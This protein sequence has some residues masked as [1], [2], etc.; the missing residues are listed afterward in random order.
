MDINTI[1]GLLLW[2]EAA[3]DAKALWFGKYGKWR[4]CAVKVHVLSP[5]KGGQMSGEI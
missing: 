1:E 5:F 3:P 2:G 4:D